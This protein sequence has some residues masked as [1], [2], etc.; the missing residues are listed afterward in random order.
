MSHSKIILGTVQFGL[1]YGINNT[2]GV[3]ATEDVFEIINYAYNHGI[4]VLDTADA[5]GNACEVIGKYNAVYPGRLLINTKFKLNDLPVRV[6]LGRSLIKLH[7]DHINVYFFHS[8]KDFV[9]IDMEQK[10]LEAFK[11]TGTINKV[12]L[13]VYDNE[14]LRTAIESDKIEVIQFPFNLLDNR[15]QRADL[16]K[17]AKEKGKELQ[18]RSVFLQGL[19]FKSPDNLPPLLTPLRPYLKMIDDLSKEADISIETLAFSYAMNQPEIDYV[20]IGVDNLI[21]LETNLQ[22][23]HYSID[24]VIIDIINRIHVQE[25]ELLYPKNWAQIE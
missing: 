4:K 10:D 2:S 12:G 8:F 22:I 13:S 21:Q 6:Q 14:E 5:Y 17:Y 20:V 16:M 19:F 9:N 23:A 7:T 18:C 3:P 1:N 15:S 24:P 25:V 11:T